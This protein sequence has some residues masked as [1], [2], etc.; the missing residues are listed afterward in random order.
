[1]ACLRQEFEPRT[2][3]NKFNIKKEEFYVFGLW[4]EIFEN[5]NRIYICVNRKEL[6][7]IYQRICHL[8]KEACLCC[9]H[10][11][12]FICNRFKFIYKQYMHYIDKP[13][14]IL[15]KIYL[16]TDSYGFELKHII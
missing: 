12:C 4:L 15:W 8:S 5:E 9:G 2:K 10:E 7:K 6:D 14:I 16:K 13:K 11:D 3:I 1:M